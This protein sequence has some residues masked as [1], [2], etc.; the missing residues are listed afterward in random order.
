RPNAT[1]RIQLHP[2]R[3]PRSD[4]GRAGPHR[5]RDA[6]HPD[7]ADAR[8]PPR[9]G[10][11]ARRP[12]RRTG[13]GST[14]VSGSPAGRDA[15]STRPGGPTYSLIVPDGPGR[16]RRPAHR[17]HREVTMSRDSVLVSAEWAEKN[18]HTPGVV[19][20]EIDEDTTA[21][22]RGHVPGAIKL[23]WKKDLQDP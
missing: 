4:Q 13:T 5:V 17:L 3:P 10:G 7:P 23:D 19:F 9:G 21:Y 2:L 16:R 22:D 8:W 14:A 15:T 11:G 1:R 6:R 12:R 18:L 20:V